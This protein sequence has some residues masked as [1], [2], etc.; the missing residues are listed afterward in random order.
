MAGQMLD[1]LLSFSGMRKG[2]VLN[3]PFEQYIHCCSA[4]I[5]DLHAP[6]AMSE[7]ISKLQGIESFA[8]SK[9]TKRYYKKDSN[10]LQ[11][12]PQDAPGL[13]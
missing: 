9:H 7:D 3:W 10:Q 13:P 12:R 11:A 8:P 6:K 4:T 2:Q 5:L 1:L